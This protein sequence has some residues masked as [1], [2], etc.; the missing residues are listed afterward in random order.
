MKVNIFN[1]VAVAVV[2]G[3]VLLTGLSISTNAQEN[4]NK[5]QRKQQRKAAQQQSDQQQPAQKQSNKQF[6]LLAIRYWT[7]ELPA[8]SEVGIEPVRPTEIII[9]RGVL[10]I[11]NTRTRFL[12]TN[13]DAIAVISTSQ[14]RTCVFIQGRSRIGR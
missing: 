6:M 11:I 12:A 1:P 4:Q 13:A 14:F 7:G 2:I 10:I 9:S 8:E 5:Q 3:G